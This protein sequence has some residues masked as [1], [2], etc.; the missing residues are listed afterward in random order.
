MKEDNLVNDYLPEPPTPT[1]KA[2]P[3]GISKILQILHIC[4]IAALKST[5]FI[6]ALTSLYSSNFSSNTYLTCPISLAMA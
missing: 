1:N 5:K 3:P 4:S 2:F 6:L